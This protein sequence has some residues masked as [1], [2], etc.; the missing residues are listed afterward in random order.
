VE[1]L[2]PPIGGRVVAANLV[3]YLS[4]I[5]PKYEEIVVHA[6]SVGGYQYGEVLLKLT[7]SSRHRDL[8]S[9]FKGIIIDSMVHAEDCAP[10]LSRAVTTNPIV[11]PVLE[12]AIKGWVTLTRPVSM[13][14]YRRSSD[15]IFANPLRLP[16]LL[17]YSCDDVVSERTRNERLSDSWRS[18]GIPVQTKCWQQSTHVL[19]Y[20]D[21]QCEYEEQLDQYLRKLRL[22]SGN[23]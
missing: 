7:S 9:A 15:Q 19:H 4:D 13:D 21:H 18:Q 23:I 16:G 22:K 3:R 17:L 10:G 2:L 20:R 8:S 6:F 11:Q 14:N 1:L 12:A 5:Q